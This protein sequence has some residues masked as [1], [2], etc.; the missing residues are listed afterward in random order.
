MGFKGKVICVYLCLFL[1]CF[2]DFSKQKDSN[3]FKDPHRMLALE[4]HRLLLELLN[5]QGGVR[6]AEVARTLGVTEETVR[7]DFEKLEAEGALMRSHGG[8]VRLEA[9]RREFPAQERAAQHAEEKARIA[10]AA[11]TRIEAGQTILFDASTTALAVAQ[12]LPDQPLTVLTNALQTALV[13][14][15]KPA[16]HV[17]MLGGTVVSRSLSCTGLSAEMMLE[18]YRID[19]AY[20]S[21]RGLE[22]KRGPSEAT[23]EQARLKRRIVECAE[24]VCLLADGSKA[25]VSSSFYFSKTAD[26]DVWITDKAPEGAFRQEVEAQGV[27]IEIA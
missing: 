23:E 4:R 8:A 7:R 21:S 17:V 27:R 6:T 16:V 12:L 9:S 11:V 14:A 20:I 2:V 18:N 3:R 1:N 22:A 5:Q 25:G 13:L 15:E 24:E 19:T 10:R 26:L